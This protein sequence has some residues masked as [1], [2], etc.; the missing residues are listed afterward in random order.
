MLTLVLMAASV[1]VSRGQE[2]STETPQPTVKR[3]PAP[4]VNA[5]SGKDMYVAYCAS[6]H[7]ATGAGNGPAASSLKTPPA[8][9]TQ[10]ASKNGGNFPYAKVQQSIKGDAEMPSAHGSKEMP[11]WGP[12][13][14]QLSR[15]NQAQ[16]QLRI[17]NITDYIASLQKK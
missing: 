9:L 10:L 11:V 7:G 13:L 17:K 3:V 15:N 5:A 14:W 16:T 12:T 6:C 2:K 4:N 1:A 8:D